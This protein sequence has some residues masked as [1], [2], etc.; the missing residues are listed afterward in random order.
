MLLVSLLQWQYKIWTNNLEQFSETSQ[1]LTL[2][3]LLKR[4]ILLNSNIVKE[5]IISAIKDSKLIYKNRTNNVD[6]YV[7]IVTFSWGHI[8]NKIQSLQQDIQ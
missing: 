2:S 7:G 1:A 4:I 6:S 8:H 3:P 5:V